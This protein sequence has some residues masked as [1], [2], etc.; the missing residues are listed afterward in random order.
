MELSA[1]FDSDG[2]SVLSSSSARAFEMEI[3][4]AEAFDEDSLYAFHNSGE[5]VELIFQWIQGLVVDACN[6]Q[7]F[8]VAPPIV[9]RIFQ[10]LASGMVSYHQALKIAK[11]PLPFPYVQSMEL[12]LVLHWIVTPPLMCM[13]VTSPL[14]TGILAFVQVFFLWSL[15]TIA[16]ELENPFGDD[17]NDLPAEEMQKEMNR[18]LLLLIEPES[19]KT[20]QLKIATA[21][22]DKQSENSLQPPLRRLMSRTALSQSGILA[23]VDICNA[24]IEERVLLGTQR[25]TSSIFVSEH[26]TWDRGVS[27]RSLEIKQVLSAGPSSVDTPEPLALQPPTLPQPPATLSPKAVTISPVNAQ[28]VSEVRDGVSEGQESSVARLPEWDHLKWHATHGLMEAKEACGLPCEGG[29]GRGL[30]ELV[31]ICREM[32]DHLQAVAAAAADKPSGDMTAVPTSPSDA[33]M[34]HSLVAGRSSIGSTA[35]AAAAVARRV[36][37][38]SMES[39]EA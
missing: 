24:E 14:W 2:D 9:S 5:K 15:N 30:E 16:T 6:D 17:V 26:C 29:R 36:S 27:A 25:S 8:S 28:G 38:R 4:D 39:G 1:G 18:R 32:R 22:E 34:T 3:I 10:E 13:W 12:L 23:P 21:D 37:D 11:M 33:V 35:V 19:Q 31:L 20:P 7:L